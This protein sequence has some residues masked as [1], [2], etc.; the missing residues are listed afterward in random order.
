MTGAL[1]TEKCAWRWSGQP[2][3]GPAAAAALVPAPITVVTRC[4]T[5]VWEAPDAHA[6]EGRLA[7]GRKKAAKR[8]RSLR[9]GKAAAGSEGPVPR[10]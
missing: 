9:D 7:R 8:R 1:L 3:P 5:G 10:L 4:S 2:R 6:R